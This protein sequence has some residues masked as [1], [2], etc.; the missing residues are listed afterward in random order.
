MLTGTDK[1]AR[2]PWSTMKTR[3]MS[4]VKGVCPG[5][6]TKRLPR[7]MKQCNESAL[8]KTKKGDDASQQGKRLKRSR[9]RT[10][11]F[12]IDANVFVG[13]R[14]DF[15]RAPRAFRHRHGAA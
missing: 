7:L 14:G 9:T 11:T 10:S 15:G 12:P 2:V 3:P 1:N 4:T 5:A 6:R 8:L 13:A